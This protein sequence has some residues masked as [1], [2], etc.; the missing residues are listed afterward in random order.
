[1]NNAGRQGVQDASCS[2]IKFA[3]L[4]GLPV[5][6]KM[7]WVFLSH[8]LY[9]MNVATFVIMLDISAYLVF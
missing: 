1:M 2:F 5:G 3:L 6:L 4:K 9:R 7:F 8:I